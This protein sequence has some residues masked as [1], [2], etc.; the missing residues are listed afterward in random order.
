MS[1]EWE[2]RAY[3][4][5]QAGSTQPMA[6]RPI[7]SSHSADVGLWWSICA[8]ETHSVLL[9]CGVTTAPQA[10]PEGSRLWQTCFGKG[11]TTE[12]FTHFVDVLFR[13]QWKA[14]ENRPLESLK[15]ILYLVSKNRFW[16]GNTLI[17]MQRQK[18]TS[19]LPLLVM[20]GDVC[21]QSDSRS[22]DK[23]IAGSFLFNN[24]HTA[25]GLVC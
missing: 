12:S 3:G 20:W 8:G 23:L 10:S 14:E 19:V 16:C 24:N 9:M 13:S 21:G 5:W 2:R 11:C 17:A 6:A 4:S 7:V 18:L 15:E 1:D 25:M 22:F